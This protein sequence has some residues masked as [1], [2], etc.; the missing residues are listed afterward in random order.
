MN[1]A[2]I[3]E[4]AKI[5]LHLSIAACIASSV[6]DEVLSKGRW[7]ADPVGSAAAQDTIGM[8]IVPFLADWKATI[9]RRVTISGCRIAGLLSDAVG[10]YAETGPSRVLVDNGTLDRKSLRGALQIC[11]GLSPPQACR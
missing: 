1:P 3:A 7:L 10:C 11:V 4:R 8:D 6:V 5:F 2:S 9:G